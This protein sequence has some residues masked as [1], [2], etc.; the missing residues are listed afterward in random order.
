[1]TMN[2]TPDLDDWE[3]SRPKLA[4]FLETTKMKASPV[5][6]RRACVMGPSQGLSY[7]FC[8]SIPNSTY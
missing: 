7:A 5:G 8:V 2:G 1:M 4:S 3:L 6:T